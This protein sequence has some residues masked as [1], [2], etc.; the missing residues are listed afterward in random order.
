MTNITFEG[1]IESKW[2]ATRTWERKE[3]KK[4][5]RGKDKEDNNIGNMPV[6]I[7]KKWKNAWKDKSSY[8]YMKKQIFVKYK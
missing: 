6:N 8:K 7:N 3:I 4:E 5:R 2:R 1:R